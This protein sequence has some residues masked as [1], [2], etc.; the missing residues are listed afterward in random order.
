MRQNSKLSIKKIMLKLLY[1]FE[2]ESSILTR[3]K[4]SNKTPAFTK[5]TSMDIC[6]VIRSNQLFIRGCYTETKFKKKK[7]LQA[8]LLHFSNSYFTA[9]VEVLLFLIHSPLEKHFKEGYYSGSV[10]SSNIVG[11][12]RKIFTAF[13]GLPLGALWVPLTKINNNH[14]TQ[15]F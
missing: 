5:S 4:H 1:R 11:L 15:I 9:I 3:K 6:V 8:K 7:V 13:Y 10:F 12:L 14:K 2:H